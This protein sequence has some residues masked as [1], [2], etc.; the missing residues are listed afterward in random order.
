MRLNVLC[1]RSGLRMPVGVLLALFKEN[2]GIVQTRDRPV[3][4]VMSGT[5]R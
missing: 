5:G 2:S 1:C 3:P 4:S